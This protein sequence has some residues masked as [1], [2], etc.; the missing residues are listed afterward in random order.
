MCGGGLTGVVDPDDQGLAAAT[1]LDDGG[2]RC[3]SVAQGSGGRPV[4]EVAEGLQMRSAMRRH[5][6][7]GTGAGAGRG[8]AGRHLMQFYCKICFIDAFNKQA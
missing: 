8:G 5:P 3:R 2:S 7:S 4:I 1:G 6:W